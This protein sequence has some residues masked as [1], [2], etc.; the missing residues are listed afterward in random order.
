M[1]AWTENH[2]A[3][4]EQFLRAIADAVPAPKPGAVPAPAV[5]TEAPAVPDPAPAPAPTAASVFKKIPWKK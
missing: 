5:A 2:Y 4:A 1:P 3:R